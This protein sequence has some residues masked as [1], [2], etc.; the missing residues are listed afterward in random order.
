MGLCSVSVNLLSGIL[1]GHTPPTVAKGVEQ[2]SAS[3]NLLSGGGR[4]VRMSTKQ[5]SVCFHGRRL[6]FMQL[7]VT[8]SLLLIT[9]GMGGGGG[10]E[11]LGGP[12]G[13][14]GGQ[15]P[16]PFSLLS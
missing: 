11:F 6:L 10:K 4:L 13:G 16:L 9:G 1:R 14:G 7:C 5:A 12:K 2:C 15:K 8:L 3:V